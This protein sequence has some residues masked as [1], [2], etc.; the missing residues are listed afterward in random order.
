M[1]Y[2]T[3]FPTRL[4]TPN[5]LSTALVVVYWSIAFVIGAAIPQVQNISGLIAAICIMQ[6]SYTFPPLLRLAY[7]IITDAMVGDG[8]Y[9][10]GQGVANRVDTWK[11]W[12][13]WKRG[14]FTGR[15]WY[16][17]FNLIIGLAALAMACLGMWGAGKSIQA[18]FKN[19][20]APSSFSCHSPVAG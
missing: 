19:A 17:A 5:C 9:T 10:P 18:T 6:F 7:D 15:V 16:K 1:S 14:L 13:R 12:S 11:D 20:G 4:L 8:P 2:S 3:A